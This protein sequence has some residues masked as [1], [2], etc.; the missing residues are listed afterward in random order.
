LA[1]LL[2]TGL[3]PDVLRGFFAGEIHFISTTLTRE[4]WLRVAQA[5]LVASAL[6]VLASKTLIFLIWD[7]MVN[8]LDDFWARYFGMNN[9]KR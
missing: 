7:Q 3:Y 9:L 1:F 2:I 8:N 5:V 6:F 4:F